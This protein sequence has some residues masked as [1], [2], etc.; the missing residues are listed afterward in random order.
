MY[1]NAATTAAGVIDKLEESAVHGYQDCHRML[2]EQTKI[3]L[4]L[5]LHI[6]LLC[7]LYHVSFILLLAFPAHYNDVPGI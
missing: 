2:Q 5:L 4:R 7:L 3:A 1:S 6:L